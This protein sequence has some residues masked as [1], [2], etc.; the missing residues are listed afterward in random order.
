M[1]YNPTRGSIRPLSTPHL[2]ESFNT[3]P[4]YERESLNS[5]Q[6]TEQPSSPPLTPNNLKVK[7]NPVPEQHPSPTWSPRRD[8]YLQRPAS[9]SN[10]ISPGMDENYPLSTDC[11]MLS[12][13]QLADREVVERQRRDEIWKMRIRMFRFIVR[14]LTLGCRFTTQ[15]MEF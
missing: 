9:Y 14:M 1:A 11:P 12:P 15:V 6:R 5:G 3:N 2:N 8:A 7:W 4:R 10:Y 13:I